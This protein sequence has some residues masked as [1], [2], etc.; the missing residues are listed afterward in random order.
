VANP[1]L[2]QVVLMA[3]VLTICGLQVAQSQQCPVPIAIT[4]GNATVEPCSTVR[5]SIPI[6]INNSC[7]VGGI[8]LRINTTDS[9]WLAFTPGDQNAAD[10][11]GSR[12][13]GW[14]MFSANVHAAHPGQM[15]IT[16]IADMPGGNEGAL[17]PPGDGLLCTIH[18][19][20]NNLLVCDSNQLITI[21]SA[22][23]SD[24]TGN[25]LYS[26]LVLN[27]DYFYVLPGRCNG[28]PRG[29]ANC[30]GSLNGLDVVYLVAYFKGSGRGFCC[31]CSADANNSG[32][33]N[34]IDVTYLVSYFKGGPALAPC[35]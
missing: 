25:I 34:G 17:L 33:V 5:V 12:I 14:D 16:A 27:N 28:N 23:V 4:I 18:L 2:T 20:Y 15:I 30:S 26:P 8:N 19:T 6:F 31:L 21:T 24:S 32:N 11:I 35:R 7:D 10:T 22:Q 1:K 13:S 3:V 29:D 9:T